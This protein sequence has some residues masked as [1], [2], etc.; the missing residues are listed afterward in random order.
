MKT[1]L[2]LKSLHTSQRTS[3]LM[4]STLILFI[5]THLN[6]LNESQACIATPEGVVEVLSSGG[7]T[8]LA[9]NGV[10]VLSG[11]FLPSFEEVSSSLSV[12]VNEM[13]AQL[14]Q[15]EVESRTDY[16]VRISQELAVG[17]IVLISYVN[18]N[19]RQDMSQRFEVVEAVE[20]LE[21]NPPQLSLFNFEQN[22]EAE[23]TNECEGGYIANRTRDRFGIVR[24]P[25]ELVDSG[26]FVMVNGSLKGAIT[27]DRIELESDDVVEMR[28]SLDAPLSFNSRLEGEGPIP[29]EAL[30]ATALVVT[31]TGEVLS[32]VE[33]CDWCVS[34]TLGINGDLL[35]RAE[36]DLCLEGQVQ[37]Y[38]EHAEEM[39]VEPGNDDMIIEA[40]NSGCEQSNVAYMNSLMGLFLIL[41]MWIRRR[42][43]NK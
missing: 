30:C 41:T 19:S 28:V 8:Q 27:S 36:S 2:S 23:E 22:I 29:P 18:A 32:S 9:T 16:I 43:F 39:P 6:D 40:E 34:K 5:A 21:V 25:A 26:S 10:L 12:T 11:Y 14:E 31:A 33:V 13:Q 7:E 17:D 38:D 20:N 35:A 4:L 15:I 1:T 3:T 24:L 37:T 42:A